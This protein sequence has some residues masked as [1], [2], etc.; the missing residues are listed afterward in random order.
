MDLTIQRESMIVTTSI[1]ANY[2][3]KARVLAQSVKKHH[4]E[5]KFVL[6][7]V[8]KDVDPRI[9]EDK[10]FD[11]ILTP[12][13]LSIPEYKSF[14]FRYTI[15]E[16]STAVK[17]HLM[18]KLMELYP[19]EKQ[20]LYMDPDTLAV[21]PMQE[22][23]EFLQKWQIV[24]TPHLTAP[25][26]A[27]DAILDNEVCALRHGAYNLGFLGI[28]RG[29]ES[30]RFLRWWADRL[31]SLCYADYARGLFT[32]QKWI[33]LAPGMF[34]IGIFKHA[35]YNAA[36]WNLSQRLATWSQDG[37]AVLMN[38]L[39]LRF[40]HFS[41]LDSGA[42]EGMVKKYCPDD[43]N[44]IFR[45]RRDYIQACD[46]AGQP[47]FGKTP[48]S[49]GFYDDG[50][51]ISLAERQVVRDDSQGHADPYRKKPTVRHAPFQF[52][53]RPFLGRLKRRIQS[54]ALKFRRAS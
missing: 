6:C 32:D 25:E 45:L 17:G 47:E 53:G 1:C 8:E 13:A 14:L 21:S 19:E 33:D 29:P 31:Y 43:R 2:I 44:P 27:M 41:G 51:R 23:I 50:T 30:S 38:G 15:V 36:P 24:L 22:L 40:F 49:Y 28:A 7:L 26:S 4:P 34:E 12:S 10:L 39:P 3:P 46:D 54:G 20:F 16:A 52:W 11:Q 42:N 35:G 5:A 48:W 37:K 9:R 18:L